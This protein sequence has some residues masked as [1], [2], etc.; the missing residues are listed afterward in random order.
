MSQYESDLCVAFRG[1]IQEG[2]VTIFKTSGL[3]DRYFV[4]SCQLTENL[5]E[6][7]LCRTQ[8][9]LHMKPEDLEYFLTE[10]IGNHHLIVTGDH[11]EAVKEFYKWL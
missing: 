9:R 3:L 10:S 8:V 11:E 4:R 5:K 6:A 7:R 2:P 1:H